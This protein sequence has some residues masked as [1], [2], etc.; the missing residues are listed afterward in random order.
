MDAAASNGNGKTETQAIFLNPFANSSSCKRKFVVCPFVEEET[1]G[2]YPFAN[3]L[4]WL[5][6]FAHL[7]ICCIPYAYV[8]TFLQ[9]S[10]ILNSQLTTHYS[11]IFFFFYSIVLPLLFH[12][13]RGQFTDVA[14]EKM[15]SDSPST[16]RWCERHIMSSLVWFG[17]PGWNPLGP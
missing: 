10:T 3:E 6:G 15:R 13:V 5:N 12:T 7:C 8:A 2:R 16:A 17:A 4:N 1:N 14:G 11:K 9:S